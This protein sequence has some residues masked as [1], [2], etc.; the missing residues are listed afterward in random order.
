MMVTYK[1]L[2]KRSILTITYSDQ[3]YISKKKRGKSF[4]FIRSHS[5]CT[6]NVFII[7]IVLFYVPG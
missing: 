1:Q 6:T 5:L 3:F 7:I 2:K 4:I